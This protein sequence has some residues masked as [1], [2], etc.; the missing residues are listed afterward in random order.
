MLKNPRL[1][2]AVVVV[3]VC[4]ALIWNS[5]KPGTKSIFDPKGLATGGDF[6]K[7]KLGEYEEYYCGDKFY[8]LRP[9]GKVDT[10][11]PKSIPPAYCPTINFTFKRRTQ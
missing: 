4:S 1:I 6:S 11:E 8:V 10:L 9:G 5:F 3:A 2:F 7:F